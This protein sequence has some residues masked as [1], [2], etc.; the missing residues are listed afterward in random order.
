[1]MLLP[2]L[3]YH[4][5]RERETEGGGGGGKVV[6][7]SGGCTGGPFRPATDSESVLLQVS[8]VHGE[9]ATELV[10]SCETLGA[11]WPG[12]R[13]GLLSGVR[14]HVRLEMVRA[15]ELPL[16]HVTLEGANAG[17]LPAV[18]TKLVRSREPLPATLVVTNIRFLARVLPDV[19]LEVGQLQVALGA[20]RVEAHKRFSLL[21]GL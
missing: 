17:V 14:A 4:T 19:H 9:V 12:A 16:A 6:A 1:M 2:F 10:R 11:V 7:H 8:S 15:G 20:S 21:L 13:M 18:S 3:C 5:H